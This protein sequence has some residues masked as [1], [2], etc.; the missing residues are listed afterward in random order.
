MTKVD[1]VLCSYLPRQCPVLSAWQMG[2]VWSQ[3]LSTWKL[4][5]WVEAMAARAPTPS[6]QTQLAQTVEGTDPH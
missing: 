3:C 2:P 6:S 1:T 4:R 5:S